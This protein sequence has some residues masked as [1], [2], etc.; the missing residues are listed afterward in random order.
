MIRSGLGSGLRRARRILVG[1]IE[2][3]LDMM[4]WP[5]LV[6]RGFRLE[7]FKMV[8]EFSLLL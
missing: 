2:T 1:S 4:S 7:R 5:T 6:E 8:V 3:R